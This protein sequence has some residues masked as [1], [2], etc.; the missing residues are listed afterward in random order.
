[1]PAT[2]PTASKSRS[3]T[4]GIVDCHT[5]RPDAPYPSIISVQPGATLTPGLRYSI[6]LHPWY[7]DQL[8]PRW[9]EELDAAV[10]QPQVAAIG[11][12]GL[13]KLRGA[14]IDTQLEVL[15]EHA[16]LSEKLKLPLILHVVKAY[17]EIIDLKRQLNP[18]QKWIIHGFRGKPELARQLLDHGFDLSL[19]EH[20]NPATAAIIPDDRL[21][22][23][24]DESTLPISEIASRILA[25]RHSQGTGS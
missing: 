2:W 23:E 3:V 4:T 1:M 22:F 18:S 25:A 14:D 15:T 16:A 9:R 12:T 8:T 10:R 5:H 24:T 20:F 21:H 7:T 17:N 19:G 11:E 13:D 6:G